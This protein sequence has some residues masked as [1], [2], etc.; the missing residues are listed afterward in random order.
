MH[1]T[2]VKLKIYNG[3]GVIYG[4]T[5]YF[6]DGEGVYGWN[7]VMRLRHDRITLNEVGYEL[8]I[9]KET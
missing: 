3:H 9:R 2:S 4:T 1:R 6:S 7:Y 8:E 5:P